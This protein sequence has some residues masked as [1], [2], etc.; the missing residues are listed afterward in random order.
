MRKSL[1]NYGTTKGTFYGLGELEDNF[2]FGKPILLV[3]GHLD[4]DTMAT[5]YP[6][7]LRNND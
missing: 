6:N 3:E 7:T 4:R 1:L 2:K 5:I